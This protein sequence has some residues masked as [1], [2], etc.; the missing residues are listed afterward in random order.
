MR[1]VVGLVNPNSPRS[2]DDRGIALPSMNYIKM[3]RE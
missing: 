1:N 2:V 3:G